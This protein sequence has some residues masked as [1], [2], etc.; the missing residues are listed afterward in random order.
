MK[1]IAYSWGLVLGLLFC[2]QAYAVDLYV[3]PN[4]SDAGDGS[5]AFPFKTLDRARKEVRNL[6]KNQSIRILFRAGTYRFTTP[7]SFN[8]GDSGTVSNPI[9]YQSAPG[10]TA[11]FDG[12]ILVDMSKFSRVSGSLENRLSP[13]ARGKVWSQVITSNTMKGLLTQSQ[14]G[15]TFSNLLFRPTRSPNHGYFN[16]SREFSKGGFMIHENTD[17]RLLQSE[18]NRTGKGEVFAYVRRQYRPYTIPISSF[19]G[20]NAEVIQ[21]KDGGFP[22]TKNDLSAG[23]RVRIRNLLPTLD[24][25]REWYYDTKESRLYIYPPGGEIKASDTLVIWGGNGAIDVNGASHIYFHNFVIQNFAAVD[26]A[27]RRYSSVVNFNNG[28]NQRLRG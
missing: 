3:A 21:L 25:P 12:G 15:L 22:G 24:I 8:S 28:R 18:Q 14:I 4:G 23:P 5:E 11:F 27:A 26:P 7:V 9:I 10:E 1:K 13:S 2:L 20:G 6:D 19:S 17:F 16:M